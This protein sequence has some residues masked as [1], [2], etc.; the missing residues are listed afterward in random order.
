MFDFRHLSTYHMACTGTFLKGKLIG[1]ERNKTS[2]F[3]CA[4]KFYPAEFIEQGSISNLP[5]F[6]NLTKCN[7]LK[8]RIINFLC[9]CTVEPKFMRG[10]N[11]L[12]ALRTES[13]AQT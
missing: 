6:P 3:F 1:K 12:H 5:T 8:I 2:V 4:K 13:G 11:N 10:G 7:T 9:Q